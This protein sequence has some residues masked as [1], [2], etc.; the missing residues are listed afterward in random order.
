MAVSSGTKTIVTALL[1]N[2]TVAVAKLFGFIVTASSSMLA[3]ALHSIADSS[4][5][6]LLLIGKKKAAALP[7][8]ERQF[9]AGRER[10]FWGFVVSLIVFSLGSVYA[11]YEGVHKI[12]APE[13]VDSLWWALAILGFAMC[14]EGFAFKTAL[15]EGK[16]LKGKHSWSNFIKRAK[17]PELPVV[18]LEDF[19]ALTGLSFAFI[20]VLLADLT[21]NPIFDGIGTLGI[22]LLLGGIAFV[23]AKETRSLLIGE[24]ALPEQADAIESAILDAEGVV[25][26]IEMRSEFV[27]PEN[28]LVAAK[29]EFS[30]DLEYNELVLAIQSVENAVR[31][32][33]PL[34]KMI[35]IEP[36]KA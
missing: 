10:F 31:V 18:L 9:G 7:S 26:L 19:G 21:G 14:T 30:A 25:A 17:G 1:A 27:G 35:Y 32:A 29:V 24:G 5:Q 11:I 20:C 33:E 12:L 4:N 8:A 13:P 22:G 15:K 28:L 34:V 3:E 2:V 23:L 16:E 6:V 36:D